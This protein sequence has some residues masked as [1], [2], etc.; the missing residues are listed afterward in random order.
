MALA[1]ACSDEECHVHNSADEVT[2]GDRRDVNDD[3]A[4]RSGDTQAAG[5]SPSVS[6]CNTTAR[7]ER[8]TRA[9]VGKQVD[10]VL[11]THVNKASP[12]HLQHRRRVVR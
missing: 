2:V 5:D 1:T 11:I 12:S 3:E 4:T 8:E 10:T 7:D 6:I 9:K